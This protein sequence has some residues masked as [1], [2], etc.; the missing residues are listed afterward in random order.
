[1]AEKKMASP[2]TYVEALYR[3]NG[4]D[5]PAREFLRRYPDDERAPKVREWQDLAETS[6][7]LNRVRHNAG[8]P[9]VKKA[10]LE[11]AQGDPGD[12]SLAF[13]ALRHDDYGDNYRAYVL[14]DQAYKAVKGDDERV[15]RRLAELQM[16]HNHEA[17]EALVRREPERYKDEKTS[18]ISLL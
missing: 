11:R 4:S 8:G 2:D 1:A 9:E 6:D 17:W 16:V 7:L 14:W 5:G 10:Y 13:N 3:L 12:E 18:R 15:A